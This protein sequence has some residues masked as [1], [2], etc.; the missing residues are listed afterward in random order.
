MK[1]LN[2]HKHID[3]KPNYVVI[4]TLM[5]CD[6]RGK[7]YMLAMYSEK[8]LKYKNDNQ[9]WNENGFIASVNNNAMF[10]L[11]KSNKTARIAEY[12]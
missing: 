2:P 7:P 6:E 4:M 12:S 5:N 10:Y 3:G 11:L 9:R 1:L 8:A